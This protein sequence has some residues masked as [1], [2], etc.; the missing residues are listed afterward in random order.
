MARNPVDQSA[1][2]T[3]ELEAKIS[4]LAEHDAKHA[5]KRPRRSISPG[6]LRR[7]AGQLQAA[8]FDSDAYNWD[9]FFSVDSGGEPNQPACLDF[10]PL[11]RLFLDDKTAACSHQQRADTS[12]SATSMLSNGVFE[13]LCTLGDP[14]L[15][16]AG[17]QQLEQIEPLGMDFGYGYSIISPHET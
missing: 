5:V 9:H 2:S 6:K 3:Q 16:G 1:Q 15:Y 14:S 11:S 17:P 12:P 8:A 10:S 7:V 4:R 13:D